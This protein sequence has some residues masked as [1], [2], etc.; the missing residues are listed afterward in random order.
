MEAGQRSKQIETLLSYVNVVSPQVWPKLYTCKSRPER[1]EGAFNRTDATVAGLMRAH[2]AIVA[3]DNARRGATMVLQRHLGV[4]RKVEDAR[5]SIPC[6]WPTAVLTAVLGTASA[7]H[8]ACNDSPKAGV[9]WVDCSKTMLMLDSRDLSG[10]DFSQARLSSSTLTGARLARAKLVGAELSFAKFDKADLS[11]A[12]LEKAVGLRA[13]FVGANLSG[14]QLV[15]SEFS[16][17]NFAQAI[18]TGANLSKSDLIRSNMSG[19]ELTGADLSKSEL[20]RV[21]LTSA[22]LS[23]ANLSYTNLARTDLHGAVLDGVDLTGAYLYLTNLAGADLT[24]TRGLTTEQLSLACGNAQ[25]KLPA[26]LGA[27]SWRCEED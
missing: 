26:G 3:Q 5:A 14:A 23:N 17:A 25:T 19:A 9:N 20:A 11:G 8:A 16:R 2:C 6:R 7:A 12:N 10:G 18:M 22:K 21:V 24:R 13:S 4:G 27:P 1:T 15:S